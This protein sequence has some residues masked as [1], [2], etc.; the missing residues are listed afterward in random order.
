MI[1]DYRC[2]NSDKCTLK[3]RN[4]RARK[5]HPISMPIVAFNLAILSSFDFIPNSPNSLERKANIGLR[6][7]A[8][9]GYIYSFIRIIRVGSLNKAQ[10]GSLAIMINRRPNL[11]T[12][13][14]A[15]FVES[16]G[17]SAISHSP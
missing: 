10:L 17:H 12:S 9:F 6:I 16:T 13:I 7:N 3:Q 1:S 14:Y 11:I 2:E 8:L 15:S 4:K 5:S